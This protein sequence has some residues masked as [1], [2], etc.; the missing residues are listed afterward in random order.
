M[1]IFT[2]HVDRGETDEM[3]TA[4][5]ETEE[6][7]G[8]R[9]SDLKVY[10]DAKKTTSYKVKGKPKTVIYWLAELINPSATVQLSDEHQDFKWLSI[11]NACLYAKYDEMVDVM[12]FCD[13]YIKCNL[14]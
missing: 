3:V 10:T 8:L 12:L 13:N 1:L 6:E 7:S 5:R 9:K 11:Q 14:K 4:F 2:G